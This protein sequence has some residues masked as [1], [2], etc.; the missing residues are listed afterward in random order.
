MDEFNLIAPVY[1]KLSSLVF[2]NSMRSAQ[3]LFLGDVPEWSNVLILGGGTGWLLADLLQTNKSCKV[4]Y[5]EASSKM[6]AL[7]QEIV[8]GE[9]HRVVFVHGTEVDIPE[10]V[11]F[12]AVISH[13]YLDLFSADRCRQVVQRIKSAMHAEGVW[14]VTDFLNTT[15]WQ[16]ALL[17]LMYAFFRTVSGIYTNV[18]PPWKESLLDDGFCLIKSKLFFGKFIFSGLFKKKVKN[19]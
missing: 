9:A 7:S 5:I 17:K 2:G 4:W 15:W 14:L 16:S 6:L 11:I 8:A 1:D 10:G 13:C 12:D 19:C 18:L 3:T